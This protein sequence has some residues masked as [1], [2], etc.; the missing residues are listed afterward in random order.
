[1]NSQIFIRSLLVGAFAATSLFAG[2]DVLQGGKTNPESIPGRSNFQI[3]NNTNQGFT[4]GGFR[5]WTNNERYGNLEPGSGAESVSY[6]VRDGRVYHNGVWSTA[7][8]EKTIGPGVTKSVNWGW[9]SGSFNDPMM[10]AIPLLKTGVCNAPL[11]Y[12]DADPITLEDLSALLQNPLYYDANYRYQKADDLGTHGGEFSGGFI[13]TYVGETQ[14]LL[15]IPKGT[16]NVNGTNAQYNLDMFS[17]PLSWMAL[18]MGQEFFGMDQQF[19]LS[20]WSKETAFMLTYN[21]GQ[22]WHRT[23]WTNSDG[24]FGPGEVEATTYMSRA[25]GYPKFWP[26]DP[27]LTSPNARDVAS[28]CGA[29]GTTDVAFAAK[30]MGADHTDPDK[31]QIVNALIGSGFVFWFNYDLLSGSPCVGFKA[32]LKESPDPYVGLCAMLPIYNLGIN[33]GAESPLLG[34]GSGANITCESFATGNGDYRRQIVAV[35]RLWTDAGQAA[36]NDLSYPLLDKWITLNDI[37]K[38]YFGD[39]CDLNAPWTAN[40]ATQD[41]GLM[42]HFKLSDDQKRAMWEEISQAFTMQAA[43][44]GGGKISLRYDWLS[45]L[46]IAKRHLDLSRGTVGGEEAGQWWQNRDGQCSGTADG[47]SLDKTYPYMTF[48]NAMQDED[49]TVEVSAQDNGANDWG[50]ASVEWTLQSDWTLFSTQNVQKIGGTAKDAL[51]KI[52]VPKAYIPDEGGRLYA[53]VT[54]S[55]GNSVVYSTPI[56]GQKLP[57]ITGAYILDTDGDG[58]GDRI[59]VSTQ[60]DSDVSVKL[61]SAT[62][63]R[64]SWPGPDGARDGDVGLVRAGTFQTDAGTLAGGAVAGLGGKVEIALAGATLKASI[65]DS[66]GPVIRYAGIQDDHPEI[67]HVL[68]SE[69]VREL[70]DMTG[71]YIQINGATAAITNVALDGSTYKFTLATPLVV[72]EVENGLDSVR[73]VP[74]AVLDQ[75]GKGA[76]DNNRYVKII[77]DKG[78]LPL[79]DDCCSYLDVDADGTMDRIRLKFK[80]PATGR[81]AP[82]T[83]S[84]RWPVDAQNVRV[85]EFKVPNADLSV[86]MVDPTVVEIDVS[87]Y[88]LKKNATYFNRAQDNWGLAHLLQESTLGNSDEDLPMADKMGPIA[89]SANYGET[90]V[91]EHRPD[92]LNVYFSEPIAAG[93]DTLFSERLYWTKSGEGNAVRTRHQSPAEKRRSLQSGTG[94]QVYYQPEHSERPGI[95]DSLRLVYETGEDGVIVDPAGNRAPSQNPWVMIGGKLRSQLAGL[96]GVYVLDET[97]PDSG[98]KFFD[99]QTDLDSL[100]KT[101]AGVGFTISFSDS[102]SDADR[103]TQRFGYEVSYFTNLGNFV[104]NEKKSFT[105]E[106]MERFADGTGLLAAVCQ[107]DGYPASRKIKVWIP[108]NYRADNGRAVGAGAYIQ[109]VRLWG[110]RMTGMDATRVFGVVRKGKAA[111]R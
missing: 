12:E 20:V 74:G 30:Y 91:P 89:V 63:L 64:Y 98:V 17:T 47:R 4:L 43:H 38:F 3:K 35:A 94:L 79:A 32:A 2:V 45:N 50:V 101:Q 52:V 14:M 34:G 75:G 27:C 19:M 67:L 54:D 58:N 36:K 97:A 103:R 55:C 104:Y 108:W 96:G 22:N 81:T 37:A 11:P 18:T 33:S 76:A 7:A 42:K 106:D 92:T 28:A 1:M 39:D 60:E 31:A 61:S 87:S 40:G 93:S 85:Q 15:A 16:V 49:F 56:K 83:F 13:D 25:M 99:Y 77:L 105:C 86:S 69:S 65:A 80:Q 62:A 5:F 90:R 44:W 29:C 70:T 48:Q 8:W 102:A 21:G 26:H 59:V 51:Y 71:A 53:R 95:G 111:R 23:L 66:V 72:S 82:M 78:P 110:N 73:I 46:R 100:A 68:F 57:K 41:G 9:A 84:F 107:V 109:Q 88:G 24:A 10:D 6:E